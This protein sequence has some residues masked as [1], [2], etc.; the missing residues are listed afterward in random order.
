[1]APNRRRSEV[2]ANNHSTE[3]GAACYT[4]TRVTVTKDVYRPHITLCLGPP[5]CECYTPGSTWHQ[6]C[7]ART[8][9][10]LALAWGEPAS[11]RFHRM[12]HANY[13]RIATPDCG[14]AA[15]GTREIP[16]AEI[17]ERAHPCNRSASNR[18]Q[19]TIVQSDATGRLDLCDFIVNA[20]RPRVWCG[21]G[22]RCVAH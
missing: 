9:S 12:C 6:K 19:R 22:R 2:R 10:P 4:V 8:S 3:S 1:V 20:F 15:I 21:P 16:C 11:K 14:S 7:E 17:D 18:K 5:V 13:E